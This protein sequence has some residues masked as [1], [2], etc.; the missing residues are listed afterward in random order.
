MSMEVTIR[1]TSISFRD[2]RRL[3]ANLHQ[4]P[5]T[6]FVTARLL[7]EMNFIK[8]A[9]CSSSVDS[10]FDDPQCTAGN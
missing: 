10:I 5:I 3:L 4:F 7:L 2:A 9:T 8:L 1:G 6:A